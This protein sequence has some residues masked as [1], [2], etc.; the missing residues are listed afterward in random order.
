MGDVLENEKK[1]DK[2]KINYLTNTNVS[3]KVK[4]NQNLKL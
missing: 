3:S 1:N 2:K 4:A